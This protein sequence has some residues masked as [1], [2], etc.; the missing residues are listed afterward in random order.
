MK[1]LICVGIVI[2][3]VLVMAIIIMADKLIK[4]NQEHKSWKSKESTKQTL[5]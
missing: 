2:N 5:S 3:V 1:I 4:L